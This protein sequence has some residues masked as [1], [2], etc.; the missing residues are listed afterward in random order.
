MYDNRNLSYT[1]AVGDMVFI[2][3]PIYPMDG[4]EPMF[5]ILLKLMKADVDRL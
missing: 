4:G 3:T 2:V 1:Y 5:S